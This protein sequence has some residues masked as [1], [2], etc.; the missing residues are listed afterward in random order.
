MEASESPA[1][2]LQFYDDLLEADS[3]NAVCQFSLATSTPMNRVF[4]PSGNGEYH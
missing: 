4:R 3:A 1:T 2:V